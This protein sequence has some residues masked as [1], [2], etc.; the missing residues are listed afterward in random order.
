MANTEW[1]LGVQIQNFTNLYNVEIINGRYCCCD[2]NETCGSTA[3]D[4]LAMCKHASTTQV[5]E[6]WFLVYT[7]KCL[8][9]T[10][11]FGKTYQL[12]YK[13]SSSIFDHGILSI[14]LME[15]ELGDKVR[16]KISCLLELREKFSNF[17]FNINSLV[18]GG[19]LSNCISIYSRY[20]DCYF[21]SK[22][23]VISCT[24]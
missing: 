13:S 15:M 20:N 22:Y 23:Q 6:T 2:D 24:N 18:S 11:S 5:C 1:F 9:G 17:A 21:C 14:P 19:L 7:R 16:T 12:N 4:L 10:C 8:S 3:N